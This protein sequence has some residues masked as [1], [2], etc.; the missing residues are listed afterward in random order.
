MVIDVVILFTV[1]PRSAARPVSTTCPTQPARHQHNAISQV[2]H[3][4]RCCGMRSAGK[5]RNGR[6]NDP[7]HHRQLPR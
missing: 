2:G 6:G 1:N 3:I 5:L 7:H 4:R